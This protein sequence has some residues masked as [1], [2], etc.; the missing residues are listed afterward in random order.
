[1]LPKPS[2][3]QPCSA[4]AHCRQSM[5]HL[6]AWC[7]CVPWGQPCGYLSPLSHPLHSIRNPRLSE[8]TGPC[9]LGGAMSI[10]LSPQGEGRVWEVKLRR[11][12][13][14]CLA[15]RLLAGTARLIL[16]AQLA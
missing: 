6:A 15:Q 5:R 10:L 16:T 2:L 9:R 12:S 1:M 8:D 13:G 7:P 3:W 11:A 14:A 4:H